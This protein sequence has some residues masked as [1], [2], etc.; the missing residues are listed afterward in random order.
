VAGPAGSVVAA[1][2]PV[3]AGGWSAPQTIYHGNPNITPY[4]QVS[5]SP[6]GEST[7]TWSGNPVQAA[8]RPGLYAAWQHPVRLGF[9]GVPQVAVDPRGNAIVVWQRP[10]SHPR[11]I[12]VQ[13]ASYTPSRPEAARVVRR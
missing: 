7:A 3:T 9:G 5:V 2:K 10:T 13:A 12:I 8:V 11:G 6:R 1:S 4:P